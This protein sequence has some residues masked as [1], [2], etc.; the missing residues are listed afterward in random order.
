[1]DQTES[2]RPL[3]S[4][5]APCALSR[6]GFITAGSLSRPEENRNNDVNL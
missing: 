3:F 2:D 1:M 6:R 4:A 5:C